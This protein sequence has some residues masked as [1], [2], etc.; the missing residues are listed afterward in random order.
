MVHSKPHQR[1]I[2]AGSPKTGKTTHGRQIADRLKFPFFDFDEEFCKEA[3]ARNL[4]PEELGRLYEQEAEVS[5]E[6]N[7]RLLELI[8]D[9]PQYVIA[10]WPVTQFPDKTLK[11]YLSNPFNKESRC[12]PSISDP[13]KYDLVFL[14]GGKS[15]DS[16]QSLF[17][18]YV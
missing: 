5:A 15:P 3:K 2:I 1:I 13:R 18:N 8:K 12:L 10:G 7:S 14:V 6:V 11:I 9:T 17:H 16:V 4:S